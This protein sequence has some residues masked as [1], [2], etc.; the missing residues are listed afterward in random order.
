MRNVQKQ[1]ELV[2]ALLSEQSTLSLATTGPGEEAC[3]APLF[4]IVDEG[5]SLY[6]ISSASSLHSLNL[7]KTPR[8]AAA[9]Y[10]YR[11]LERDLRRADA[12]DDAQ[13]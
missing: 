12:G 8:A 6:W 9:V 5:L 10:R 11:Q 4:Y 1:W 13:D 2:A 7:V 3:V